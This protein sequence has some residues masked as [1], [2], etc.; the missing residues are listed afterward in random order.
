MKPL[1][2]LLLAT[3]GFTALL[4]AG[5]FTFSASATRIPHLDAESIDERRNCVL[6]APPPAF[7][8]TLVCR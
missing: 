1:R 5:T 6:V 2:H 8:A 4:L 3:L 7:M